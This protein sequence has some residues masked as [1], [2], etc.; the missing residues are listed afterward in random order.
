VPIY[1]EYYIRNNRNGQDEKNLIVPGD[2]I[3]N[4]LPVVTDQQAGHDQQTIPYSSTG[5]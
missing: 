1:P 5:Q 3:Y 2:N 4:H